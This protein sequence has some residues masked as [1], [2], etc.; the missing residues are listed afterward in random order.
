MLLRTFLRLFAAP[1]PPQPIQT[2]GPHTV[3][4]ARIPK[5]K[6]IAKPDAAASRAGLSKSVTTSHAATSSYGS[7]RHRLLSMKLIHTRICSPKRCER[8]ADLGIHTAGDLA[9]AQP[10]QLAAHFTARHKALRILVQYRR[11][12]RLA[13]SVP[14]MMPRDAMLL[15]S[16][17][18][19]SVRGLA[20]ESAAIVHRDLERF[21]ESSRG[22]AQMRGRRVPSTRR[23][24]RWIVQCESLSTAS[25]VRSRVA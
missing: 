9:A 17:H 13:A 5:A 15:I 12:I 16:I 8:L 7:H 23:I 6:A 20:S 18:R 14:G 10:E 3:L 4:Y 22:R 19:R 24:R 1:C 21:S 11:A 25:P 2:D